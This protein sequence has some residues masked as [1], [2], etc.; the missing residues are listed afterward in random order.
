MIPPTDDFQPYWFTVLL[1]FCLCTATEVLPTW[2]LIYAMDQL[3]NY[4]DLW[5]LTHFS[6]AICVHL[7]LH[8][9]LFSLPLHPCNLF[10]L[11]LPHTAIYSKSL[12]F[13]YSHSLVPVIS[14]SPL[15]LLLHTFSIPA[16]PL[17]LPPLPLPPTYTFM[18]C[19]FWLL[20]LTYSLLRRW[21]VD[22]P[23][24]ETLQLRLDRHWTSWLSWRCT[25]SLWRSWNT[26][27][28]SF[29]STQ[30]ILWF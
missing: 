7:S 12:S 21:I 24:L 2:L 23:F 17:I 20:P 30:M 29:L 6:Q 11:L 14:V 27:P 1:L 25:C 18:L 19:T 16:L 9:F 22:A 3:H 28:L 5:K 26:W 4:S 10:L 15:F 13:C 8:L